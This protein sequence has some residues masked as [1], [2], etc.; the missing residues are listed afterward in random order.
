MLNK[1]RSSANSFFAKLLLGLLVVSFGVWGIADIFRGYGSQTL[2]V[3]GG[4][5]IGVQDY[6]TALNNQIQQISQQA[7]KP[8]TM[9]DA[10]SI[11][12]DRRVL[13]QMVAEAAL[14]KRA[15]E[16]GLALN[17]AAVAKSLMDNPAFLGPDG[18]FDRS[19]FDEAIRNAGFT[20]ESFVADQ[21]GFLLRRQLL[22]ALTGG[23]KAPAPLVEAV[24][25]F[26][27]ASRDI[28]YVVLGPQA[29]PAVATPDDKT[30]QAFY[31]EHKAEFRTTERRSVTALPLTIAALAPTEKVDEAAIAKRYDQERSKFGVPEKRT[32]ERI[33]FPSMDE[34]K[35]AAAKLAAGTSFADLAKA[36]KLSQQDISLGTVT[37]GALIDQALA[38]TA[39]STP[40]GGTSQPVQGQFSPT[41]V[42]VVKVEPASVK[43]LSAVKD[44][45][46]KEI[47]ADEARQAL[48]DLRDAIEDALAGGATLPEIAKKHG[49]KA[50]TLDN[51]DA[52]GRTPDGKTPDVANLQ[53]IV[54]AAFKSDVGADNDAIQLGD[55]GYIWYDVAKIDPAH[56]RSFADAKAD[57]TKAWRAEEEQK[58]LDAKADDWVKALNAGKTTLADVAKEAHGTIAAAMGLTRTGGRAPEELGPGAVTSVFAAPPTGFGTADAATS[59]GRVLFQVTKATEP[60][61]NPK[62]GQTQ[63]LE[64]AL[65]QTLQTD[66]ASEYVQTLQNRYGVRVNPSVLA[67]VTGGPETD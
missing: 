3:V 58:R 34:A 50:E 1:L 62:A 9:A 6:R 43:P 10:R 44:Q 39:F 17:D 27:S 46:T 2:A 8:L 21:R 23:L 16:L 41:I 67:S 5:E 64:S 40:E 26:Q 48:G 36:R 38:N 35:A 49:L 12:L 60:P 20:E 52:Q 56:D 7:G 18:K 65:S 19:R 63:Q 31:Q 25:R 14:D 57:V 61:L 13:G 30:L 47:Q 53:Q 4:Q 54:G 33:T 11:G 28:Q 24:H 59:P 32:I 22:D 29:I 15:D 45:I 55:N 42:H 51:I 37:K 66:L